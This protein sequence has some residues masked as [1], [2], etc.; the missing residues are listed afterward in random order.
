MTRYKITPVPK[1]RMTRRDKRLNPPRPGV[2]KYYALKD[3]VNL[4]H[5]E[6]PR[7]G[8]SI[9]FILPMPRS[10]S[11]VKKARMLGKAHEVRPDLSNLLKALE[12]ALFTEDSHIWHYGELSKIWG[13]KGEIIIE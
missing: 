11:G 8:S 2:A 9:C 6:L 1:P 10:W 12:D 5:I 7:A 4:A 13:I 3:L